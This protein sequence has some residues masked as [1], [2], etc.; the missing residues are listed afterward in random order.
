MLR[1][2]RRVRRRRFSA[3]EKP[4][5][6]DRFQKNKPVFIRKGKKRGR[7]VLIVQGRRIFR[8]GQMLF[9]LV[10]PFAVV[11]RGP[12]VSWGCLAL[13]RLIGARRKMRVPVF[14]LLP[15]LRRTRIGVTR[16]IIRAMILIF[17]V[18]LPTRNLL[19][20]C[21]CPRWWCGRQFRLS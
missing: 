19:V 20:T 5:L 11:T 4:V 17:V 3:P 8:W 21:G 1:W 7:P 9:P 14:P 18:L 6:L 15:A 2:V 12:P 13:L 16:L 10:F